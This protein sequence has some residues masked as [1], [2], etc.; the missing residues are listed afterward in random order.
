MGRVPTSPSLGNENEEGADPACLSETK[1]MQTGRV[2]N[3]LRHSETKETQT[4]R[5]PTSMS[6]GNENEEG[7]DPPCCLEI[8]ET[9]TGRVLNSP[10]CVDLT[11]M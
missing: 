11:E 4:G 8:K 6:L 3:P 10:H 9:Q 1:E 7:A 5:V 2:L